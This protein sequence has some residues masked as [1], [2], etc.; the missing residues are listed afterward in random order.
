MARGSGKAAKPV[1]SKNKNGNNGRI[2]FE[3]E[4]LSEGWALG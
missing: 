2:G 3:A 4:L 1:T